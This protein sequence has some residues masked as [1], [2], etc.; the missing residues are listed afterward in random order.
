MTGTNRLRLGARTG[1]ALVG[2]AIALLTVWQAF[3]GETVHVGRIT[4]VQGNETTMDVQAQDIASPGIGA[5]TVDVI[6]D[7]GIVE[8]VDCAPIDDV[9]LCNPTYTDQ[10]VRL[11]G[12][13][14]NGL[15]GDTTLAS[16]RFRCRIPGQSV[17][18][19]DIVHLFDAT[20]GHP[21]SI[22]ATIENGSITCVA[23]APPRLLGDVDCNGRVNSIDAALVLQ[24][25]ARLIRSL[26]CPQNGDV[27]RDGRIDSVDA[28]LILQ[29]EAHIIPP[30]S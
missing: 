27:N 24:L 25:E 10:R 19:L 30:R 17:L 6:Y 23:P 8:L 3:A 11:V 2:L 21:R 14:P 22:S 9:G 7:P 28:T 15:E 5:W 13:T 4:V 18:D 29:I 12:A 20:Q 16:L 26:P 1:A